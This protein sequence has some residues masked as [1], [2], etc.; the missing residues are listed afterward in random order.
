MKKTVSYLLGLWLIFSFSLRSTAKDESRIRIKEEISKLLSGY[1]AEDF[2]ALA[3]LSREVFNFG[4]SGIQEICSRLESPITGEKTAVR[5]AV[6]GLCI[7]ANQTGKE[8]ERQTLIKALLNSLQTI[9]DK[10]AQ[11]FLISQIQMAGKDEAVK[12]L[13]RYLRDEVLVEPA[14]R[15]LAAIGGPEASR[16]LGKALSFSRGKNI[17]HIIQAAGEI[18]ANSAV[19]KLT[20]LASVNDREIRQAAIEALANIGHQASIAIM[21]K[22]FYSTSAYESTLSPALYL[23]YA[24]R[25]A[26]RGYRHQALRIASDLWKLY[27]GKPDNAIAAQALELKISLL[28]EN[29]AITEIINALSLPDQKLR[30]TAL[31]LSTRFGCGEILSAL[32]DQAN[33]TSSQVK[34]EI[35]Y[36]LSLCPGNETKIIIKDALRNG[37]EWV[38]LAALDAAARIGSEEFLPEI[39]DAL[40]LQL[41]QAELEAAK[42]FLMRL[43]AETANLAVSSVI[44]T[45]APSTQS[46]ILEVIAEKGSSNEAGLIFSLAEAED[47]QVKDVA[48][49]ALARVS[50][51][52]DL[53]RLLDMFLR[54][55][56]S[57]EIKHLRAAIIAVGRRLPVETGLAPLLALM[58][59]PSPAVRASL[60]RILPD[61]GTDEAL[62]AVIKETLSTDSTV[63]TSAINALSNWPNI[64]AIDEL[65]KI[66]NLTENRKHLS[67][68]LEGI[69]RLVNQ[70][71]LP[72]WKKHE[73]FKQALTIPKESPDKKIIVRA[74]SSFRDPWSFK[75]LS[76]CLDDPAL[77]KEAS[78]SLLE[79]ASEQAPEERWLS[80]HEA[81]SILRRVESLTTSPE[82][83]IRGR[84]IIEN[85]LRQGGFRQLFNGC[86]LEGWKGLVADPPRR[87]KMSLSELNAAQIAA[88]KKMRQHWRVENGILLFDG[89]G[90]NI[91]TREQFS[92]FELLVDWKIES[93]GDSGIYLRGSPQVQIWDADQNPVGSGG[94]YNNQ[95]NPSA[96]LVKADKPVGEWNT[97]RI[98]MIGNRVTVYLNDQLVVNNTI[99]ENYWERNK[100]IYP[101]GE[102]EL[103][104]H[105]NCLFFRNIY[106]RP[107]PHD[108]PSTEIDEFERKEG[109]VPIFNGTDL[110]GWFGAK[111][112]YSVAY[113]K[114][115]VRPEV[116]G[117]T[118]YTEKEYQNFIL[119]LEFKLY[120]ASKNGLGLRMSPGVNVA[121]EGIEI[122]IL[123][124]SSPQYWALL[125]CQ[126]HGSIYGL[127]PARRGLLKPP[128]DWNSQ[129]IM[130]D[131]RHLRVVLNGITI[132]DSDIDRELASG[133]L[134]GQELPGFKSERGYLA[135]LGRGSMVEFRNIRLKNLN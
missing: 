29:I 25:L 115:M 85:R 135:L 134:N 60:L 101:R 1:P 57:A 50:R 21:S 47:A 18:R 127:V 116:E 2:S 103:Q 96:P 99:F 108:G 15:A 70:S 75:L 118:L 86:D 77:Q 34:A 24:R 114:L 111:E 11:S 10:E 91:C 79:L 54:A 49:R 102:I 36:R 64:K 82:E 130:F 22:H 41:S 30:A 123:D 133:T 105:G 110:D 129:E 94:L 42:N 40:K 13:S 37:E 31:E 66:A 132:V 119:R 39:L 55:R 28:P 4:T 89:Q 131:N 23:L 117:G 63:K 16:I 20:R 95:I 80:G 7:Y 71:N 58:D 72:A 9:R 109:F 88:D 46:V 78:S 51:S 93:N 112:G 3:S 128:G 59:N 53:K 65:F 52:E 98:I 17:K 48:L 26:E 125:P 69:A 27:Q 62:N 33:K 120:P 126:Y 87:A 92:D 76:S 32:L 6:Y 83:K 122:Q 107:I 35:L 12:P 8:K 90:E 43:P 19:K 100:P 113:G 74:L 106:I 67:V 61:I 121:Y 45:L 44:K 5:Y 38:R 73:F 56:D 14:S 84:Q 81:I 97:F 68:A 104:A 124:D